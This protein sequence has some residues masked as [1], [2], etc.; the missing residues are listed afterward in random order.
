VGEREEEEGTQRTRR[1]RG[2]NYERRER[3]LQ[4]GMRKMR[5]GGKLTVLG[6]VRG[7]CPSTSGKTD[8]VWLVL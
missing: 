5:M 8:I 7:H 1:W 3:V 2:K 4:R 6:L